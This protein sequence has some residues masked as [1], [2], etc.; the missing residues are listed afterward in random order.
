MQPHQLTIP[1]RLSFISIFQ[2]THVHAHSNRYSS[3]SDGSDESVLGGVHILLDAENN[4]EKNTEGEIIDHLNRKAGTSM[5][6]MRR[7]HIGH[8]ESL[9]IS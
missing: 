5:S 6:D 9:D 1:I 2:S 4:K 3:S 8:G 7:L